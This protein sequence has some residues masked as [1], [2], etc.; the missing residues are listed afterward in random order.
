MR[1]S[2][3]GANVLVTRLKSPDKGVSPVISGQFDGNTIRANGKEGG[4]SNFCTLAFTRVPEATP[5][6][7]RYD[8]IYNGIVQPS[9]TSG[10]AV[11][12]GTGFTAPRVEVNGGL[13]VGTINTRGC[14]DS[15]FSITISPTDDVKGEGVTCNQG[16]RFAV[17]GRAEGRSLDLRFVG[18]GGGGQDRVRLTR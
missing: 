1:V 13:G 2:V 9:G 4:T 10:K 7:G 6:G 15:S 11:P 17:Q 14:G 8:G 5:R 18:V 12:L 16:V 3:D